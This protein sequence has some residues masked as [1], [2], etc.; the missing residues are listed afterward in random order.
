MFIGDSSFRLGNILTD[1]FPTQDSAAIF[2][3]YID[4]FGLS[5]T[6][7]SKWYAPLFSGCVAGEYIATSTLGV[8]VLGPLHEAIIEE[9]I[10]GV[11]SFISAGGAVPKAEHT[12]H[13]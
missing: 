10:L 13:C 12:Q 5:P 11:A 9:C 7:T 8:R 6:G 1:T 4:E 3:R 2:R